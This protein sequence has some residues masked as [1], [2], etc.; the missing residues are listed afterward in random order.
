MP[1]PV[2]LLTAVLAVLTIAG[3]AC[4]A[5]G[6]PGSHA[7]SADAS[8]PDPGGIAGSRLSGD[9]TVSAAS[10]LTDAFTEMGEGFESA[11]PDTDVT[12]T[13]DS[14]GTLSEQIV[15]GAPVDVFASADEANMAGLADEGLLAGEPTIFAR[16]ELAIVT[17]PGNPAAIDSLADLASAG[18]VALCSETAPCG[19]FATEALDR[20]GVEVPESNV[21]RGRNARA[22]LTAVSEGDAVAGIVYVTDALAAGG[23]VEAVTIP[24]GQ[25][26]IALHLVGVL[27]GAAN[28]DVAEAFAA[29]VASEDGRL[30]LE[31]HGFLPPE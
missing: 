5:G 19:R 18:V 25:N 26:A 22:T 24:A 10:S 21:T 4:G 31:E 8:R 27:D 6:G 9:I 12:F 16:N 15:S 28:P 2:H 13:F 7:P 14:S 23:T 3:A 1:R 29:Y 17:E 11:H 20:A 30:V